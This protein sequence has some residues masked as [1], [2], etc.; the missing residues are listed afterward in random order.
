[1]ASK[2]EILATEKKTYQAT[3]KIFNQLRGGTNPYKHFYV[4]K[5][6]AYFVPA[7]ELM[8]DASSSV[9]L[10]YSEIEDTTPHPLI[11][12]A[13]L[14]KVILHHRTIQQIIFKCSEVVHDS[15]LLCL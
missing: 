5:N 13:S 12:I 9:I 11:L 6:G 10:N 4:D 7:V 3:N 2:S 8:S 1:M 15:L 14:K